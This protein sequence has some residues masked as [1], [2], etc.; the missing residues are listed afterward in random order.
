MQHWVER[1]AQA[2]L[3]ESQKTDVPTAELCTQTAEDAAAVQTETVTEDRTV[4]A[5][6]PSGD[7]N[8]FEYTDLDGFSL[9]AIPI[10]NGLERS[11]AVVG[12]LVVE[13]APG[14]HVYIPP[15]LAAAVASELLERGDAHV[16]RV[17]EDARAAR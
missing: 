15:S 10:R 7:E 12:F 14:H 16:L 5:S 4:T 11:A 8:P 17:V 13:T 3:R 2:L 1:C 6:P 9:E